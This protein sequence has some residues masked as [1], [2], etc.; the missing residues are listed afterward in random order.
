MIRTLAISTVVGL[1]AIASVPALA[2]DET[3]PA[4]SMK[5]LEPPIDHTTTSGAATEMSGAKTMS[6]R[7]AESPNGQPASKGTAT[8]GPATGRS[9]Q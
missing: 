2:Q 6:G 4:T 8:G 3:R 5:A 9:N 1:L 7:S